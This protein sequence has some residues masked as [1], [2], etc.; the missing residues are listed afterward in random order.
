MRVVDIPE[1]ARLSTAEKILLVEDL[2]DSIAMDEATVPV[3]AS[4]KAELDSRMK[5]FRAS[6]GV[7]LSLE[8]LQSRFQ[9]RS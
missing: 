6:P 4:H 8:D 3:P 7:L 2:W 5:A 1:L 9:R